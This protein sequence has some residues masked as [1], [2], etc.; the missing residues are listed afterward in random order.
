MTT[1]PLIT[2]QFFGLVCSFDSSSPQPVDCGATF[3]GSSVFLSANLTFGDGIPGPGAFSDDCG[4]GMFALGSNL[5]GFGFGWTT[6]SEPGRVCTATIHSTNA[7][8][9]ESTA[10]ALYRLQ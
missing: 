2:V 9:G 8:G 7:Q 5:A 3:A 1:P 10:S 6:P 4:G